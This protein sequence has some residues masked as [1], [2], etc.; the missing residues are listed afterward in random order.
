[1]FSFYLDYLDYY[2]P[3]SFFPFLSLSLSFFFFFF[4]SIYRGHIREYD[5]FFYLMVSN[6]ELILGSLYSLPVDFVTSSMYNV[7]LL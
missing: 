2:I 1:M 4:S 7:P 3:F 6:N 5:S